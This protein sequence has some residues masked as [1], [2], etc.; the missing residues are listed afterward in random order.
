MSESG[1][2]QRADLVGRTRW[3]NDFGGPELE[4]LASYL[5]LERRAML[6]IGSTPSVWRSAPSSPS[7]PT[8]SARPTAP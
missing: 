2:R 7:S 1:A 4:T 5:R 3:A 6:T 8:N